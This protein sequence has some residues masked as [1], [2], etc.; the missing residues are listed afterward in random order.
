MILSYYHCDPNEYEVIFTSGTTQA[1]KLVGELFPFE[2][3]GELWYVPHVHTSVLGLRNTLDGSTNSK[4]WRCF[5]HPLLYPSFPFD[6]S[7]VCLQLDSLPVELLGTTL[8]TLP[9]ECNLSGAK[10]NMQALQSLL[11]SYLDPSSTSSSSSNIGNKLYW[12]LDAA[13][14]SGSD[15]INISAIPIHLQPHFIVCSFYKIFGYPT[16]IGCL[17]AKKSALSQLN[18]KRYFG[19]GTMLSGAVDSSFAVL[20]SKL[21]S[22]YYED[23]TLNIHGIAAI[24]HGFR[25]IE[26]LG[27]IANISKFTFQLSQYA[28]QQMRSLVHSATNISLCNI[29]CPA[30]GTNYS[31]LNQGKLLYFSYCLLLIILHI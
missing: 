25:F 4:R 10:L 26:S 15:E 17:L 7:S 18:D 19:G 14:L 1:I 28:L 30:D 31:R 16:G 27:G 24:K 3:H 2:Q 29:Y 11:E 13:K 6:E 22:D 21:Q 23:G 5:Y 9:G 8:L 20:K 12:L